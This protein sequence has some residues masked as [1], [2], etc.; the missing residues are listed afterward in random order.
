MKEPGWIYPV[1]SF[2]HIQEM[3]WVDSD[4]SDWESD[5]D[6]LTDVCATSI[7]GKSASA[8]TPHA[9]ARDDTCMD[10]KDLP[11]HLQPLMEW[12]LEDIT[13][14]ECEELAVD[15]YEYRDV[16]SSGPEDMGQTDLV[17]HTIDTGEHRPI[18]LPPPPRRLPIT[19][20][21]VEKLKSRKCWTEV[22]LSHARAAGPA[23]LFWLLRKLASPGSVWITVR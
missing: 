21:D 22:S 14:R 1:E 10:P 2:K 3:L 13:T 9:N 17:T 19:Q 18:C 15:I 8:K 20:Q 4:L 7:T 23:L 12:I 6:E 5:D 11:E 16:F